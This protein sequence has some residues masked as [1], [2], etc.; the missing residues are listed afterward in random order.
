MRRSLS[1]TKSHAEGGYVLVLMVFMTA[2]LVVSTLSMGLYIKTEAK[3]EKEEEMI[4]RGKQYVRGIKLYVRKNQGHFPTSL[5]DLIKPGVGNIH[6]MRQAYKDP[7]NKEDG[8]WRLLYVGPNGQLIG[9]LKP[10]QSNLQLPQSG[11]LGTPASSVAGASGQQPAAPGSPQPGTPGAHDPSGGAAGAIPGANGQNPAGTDPNAGDTGSS[12]NPQ[13]IA[14]PDVPTTIIGGNIIG[15][16]SKINERS[17]KVYEK[18]K[19][20]R[21]FEFYWDP[22][23]DAQN[24]LQG[25][26]TQTGPGQNPFGQPSGNPTSGPGQSPFGQPPPNPTNG[27]GNGSPNPPQGGPPQQP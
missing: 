14:P 2:V 9:S 5:D 12:S 21:L 19:N 13:P 11:G 4:W 7:M 18:A 20:Y 27:T 6:Y 1:A 23:K 17:I 26:A 15:V 25:A 22:A 16:G 10:P 24:A 8:K 3:R